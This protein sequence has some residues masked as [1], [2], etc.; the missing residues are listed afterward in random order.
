MYSHSYGDMIA[1][2]ADDRVPE[3]VVLT[4]L[5]LLVRAEQ[6]REPDR[7]VPAGLPAQFWREALMNDADGPSMD[8]SKRHR[9]TALPS[10]S[11]WQE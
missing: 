10:T 2:G 4:H 9:N 7:P 11:M 3:G 5:S 6:R 8:P 1:T